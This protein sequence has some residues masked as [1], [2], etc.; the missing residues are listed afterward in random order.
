VILFF[1]SSDRPRG[2]SVYKR[3]AFDEIEEEIIDPYDTV[4]LVFLRKVL[5]YVYRVSGV[6]AK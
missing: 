1:V 3:K 6:N 4:V 5:K 2:K